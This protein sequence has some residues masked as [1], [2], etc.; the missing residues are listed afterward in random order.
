MCSAAVGLAIPMTAA[1][2]VT[3]LTECGP[4][5]KSGD[6][7]LD[8]N[9][10]AYGRDCF[11]VD[12]SRVTLSLNGHKIVVV[13]YQRGVVLRGSHDT[14]EGGT[15]RG[16]KHATGVEILNDNDA[17]HA[18][19]VIGARAGIEINDKDNEVRGNIVK[20]NLVGIAVYGQGN[21]IT[22]N[23]ANSNDEVDLFD[24]KPC[25][26]NVWEHNHFGSAN[27]ACIH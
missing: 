2:K 21:T 8:A 20:D 4:I 5:Y 13:G 27:R 1:A 23:F 3:H 9:L 22:G 19:T 18:V 24:G 6:Y 26:R 14:V 10:V 16:S 7:V 15:I 11:S 17:V 12:R 25:G